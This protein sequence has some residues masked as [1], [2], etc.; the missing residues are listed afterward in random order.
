MVSVKCSRREC[1]HALVRVRS[2]ARYRLPAALGLALLA[3]LSA[4]CG[5]GSGAYTGP[6]GRIAD[7]ARRGTKSWSCSAHHFYIPIG[8]ASDSICSGSLADTTRVVMIAPERRAL[9]TS[10]RW[11]VPAKLADLAI[12]KL[13]SEFDRQFGAMYT[14][15]TDWQLPQHRFWLADSFYVSIVYQDDTLSV[16]HEL[17]HPHCSRR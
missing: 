8:L 14:D 11:P 3:A 7:A 16:Y 4:A 2:I 5:R 6:L 13:A 1:S 12:E 15:C 17:G 9:H 10:T